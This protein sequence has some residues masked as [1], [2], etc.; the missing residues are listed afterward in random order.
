VQLPPLSP[1]SSLLSLSLT[2]YYHIFADRTSR[3]KGARE[4]ASKEVEQLKLLKDD[5][6]K[7]FESKHS[8]DNSESQDKV[9]ESTREQLSK[10][11]SSFDQNRDK[12]VNQLLE[13]V[14]QVKAEPHRNLKV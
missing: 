12:V 5:E 7:Q 10:I 2:V 9:N 13:R 6:F 3:L 4:E 14:V 8:N 1:L 11:V